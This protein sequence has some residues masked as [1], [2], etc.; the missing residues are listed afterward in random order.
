MDFSLLVGSLASI[1]V[2]FIDHRTIYTIGLITGP[3]LDVVP[4]PPHEI[5]A[6]SMAP[7]RGLST[8]RALKVKQH[9]NEQKCS[10]HEIGAFL[11]DLHHILH[12]H[13]VYYIF[14]IFCILYILYISYI[15]YIYIHIYIY[16]YIFIY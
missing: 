9:K 11:M 6:T 7:S 12:M 10:G 8:P 3:G 16:I 15:L 2:L 5:K 14:Y 1:T 13:F 4:H